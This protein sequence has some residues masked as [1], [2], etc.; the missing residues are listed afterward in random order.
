MDVWSQGG[1]CEFKSDL[2]IPFSR[3]TMAEEAGLFLFRYFH[4]SFGDER[5]GDG[6]TQKVGT[7]IDRIS[8]KHGEDVV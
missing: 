1:E 7:F 4:L 3:G 2:I 5:A 6:S 8:S